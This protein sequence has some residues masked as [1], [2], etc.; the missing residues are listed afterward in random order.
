MHLRESNFQKEPSN[1]Q[2]IDLPGYNI[3]ETPTESSAGGALMYISQ[4]LLY[5][6]R[7]DLHI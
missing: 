4:S 6:P 3:E 1:N 5:K 7:K 2:N